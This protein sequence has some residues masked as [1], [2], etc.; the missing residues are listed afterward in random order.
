MMV[1]IRLV[2][3]AAG[4]LFDTLAG[5]REMGFGDNLKGGDGKSG[6]T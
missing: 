6:D 5:T 2:A 3:V 1:A 4:S